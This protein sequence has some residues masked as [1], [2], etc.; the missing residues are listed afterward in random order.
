MHAAEGELGSGARRRAVGGGER[1]GAEG[2]KY[3]MSGESKSG[4]GVGGRGGQ[5]FQK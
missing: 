4:G 5:H 3:L 2:E 1:V